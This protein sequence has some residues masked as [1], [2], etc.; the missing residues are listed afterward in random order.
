[1][2]GSKTLEQ[3]ADDILAVIRADSDK[4]YQIEKLASRFKTT[5]QEIDTALNTIE[6]WAYKLDRGKREVWFVAPPDLITATEIAWQQKTK[7]LGKHI[8]AYQ[9][10]KSTNDLATALAESGAD[11][12][13]IV[14]AE[15][16][17][18]GRG[19]FA[20][21]WHSPSGKNIYMSTVLRPSF[22]PEQAP[23]MSIMTAV[24]LAET[25]DHYCP[26]AV[27]IKWPN[28][29]L[30]RGKKTAGILTELS[31]E[32]GKISHV[33]IGVGINVNLTADEFPDELRVI[34]TS[35][36]RASRKKVDRVPLLQMFL[37]RL[38]KRYEQYH[39]DGLKPMHKLVREYSSLI[40]HEV[41][42]SSGRKQTTGVALD[43]DQNGSLIL[44]TA[45]GTIAVTSGEVTVAKS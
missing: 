17:T 1:M 36:R 20:R 43:I 34:A 45:D 7:W 28:D 41:T 42:L 24:A 25:I 12:G 10:V 38:E 18:Q 4:A 27:R 14:T 30:I 26:D 33:V 35:I 21:V 5:A 22:A 13:T 37:Q 44:E 8:H 19:R 3:L 40:G 23:G 2:A 9:S 16:Q 11:H 29:V 6:L 32:R 39:R 31:A 15:E